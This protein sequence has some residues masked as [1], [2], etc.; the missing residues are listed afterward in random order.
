VELLVRV[1]PS[2]SDCIKSIAE[3]PH[4]KTLLGRGRAWFAARACFPPAFAVVANPRRSRRIRYAL[5]EKCLDVY[6][7]SLAAD[8]SITRVG[9][10]LLL[11]LLLLLAMMCLPPAP[12]SP[13][14]LV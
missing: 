4:I 12:S 6:L 11:L 7:R 3:M 8:Q 9:S 2:A 1:D 10:T 14:G 13:L 5:M